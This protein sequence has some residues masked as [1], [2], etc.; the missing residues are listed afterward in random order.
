MPGDGEGEGHRKENRDLELELEP[1]NRRTSPTAL[2]RDSCHYRL[3]LW[4]QLF[5]HQSQR[6]CLIAPGAIQQGASGG[7]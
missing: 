2:P 5:S 4:L 1:K 7:D 6:P 3:I